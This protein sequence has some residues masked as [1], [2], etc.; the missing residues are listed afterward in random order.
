MKMSCPRARRSWSSLPLTMTRLTRESEDP[1]LPS[2]PVAQ[3]RARLADA[4]GPQLLFGSSLF[5]FPAIQQALSLLPLLLSRA[6]GPPCDSDRRT[7]LRAGSLELGDELLSW[8]WSSDLPLQMEL[9]QAA[10]MGDLRSARTLQ[11]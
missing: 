11:V 5:P 9:L 8:T 6:E 2:T 4:G 7:P 1:R 10:W 3:T